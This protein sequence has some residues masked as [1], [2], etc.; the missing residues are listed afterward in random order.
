MRTRTLTALADVADQWAG[1]VTRAELIVRPKDSNRLIAKIVHAEYAQ[2][3]EILPQGW[4]TKFHDA[5]AHYNRGSQAANA[6]AASE[7]GEIHLNY[8]PQ[9]FYSKP[10]EIIL[11][12]GAIRKLG[13]DKSMTNDEANQ[14]R[15]IVSQLQ[16]DTRG[17]NLIK[18]KY[19][20]WP[21]SDADTPTG[22]YKTMEP[23]VT[24]VC[25]V[26]YD[27]ST[28]PEYL[29]QSHPEWAPM[30]N[31]AESNL[32]GHSNARPGRFVQIVK[33]RNYSNCEQRMGFHH[34]L[35]GVNDFKPNTNQMGEFFTV[36][37]HAN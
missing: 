22:V 28:I 13:V 16:V 14:L 21:Q 1:I 5:D 25:E 7:K 9:P 20:N 3:N 34:G 35:S 10:F 2:L 32:D 33:T 24:G 11:K 27:V 29:I 4:N 18:C 37:R 15:G 8:Q 30:P 19:N 17:Q 23:S 26:L 6:A 36:S 12:N 31:L